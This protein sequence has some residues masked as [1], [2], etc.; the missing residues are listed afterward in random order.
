MAVNTFAFGD[1]FQGFRKAANVSLL[2]YYEKLRRHL[3]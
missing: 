1:Q 3:G 2:R